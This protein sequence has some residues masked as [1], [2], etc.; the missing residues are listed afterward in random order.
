MTADLVR[1]N[2]E[3]LGRPLLLI[4]VRLGVVVVDPE[5]LGAAGPELVELLGRGAHAGAV[6]ARLA[7]EQDRG[8]AAGL[9]AAAGVDQQL[10]EAILGQA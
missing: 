10:D 1:R 4:A 7:D 6:A 5:R 2:A 8:E 9:E 3:G